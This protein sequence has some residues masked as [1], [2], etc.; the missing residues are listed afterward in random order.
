MAWKFRRGVNQNGVTSEEGV[1]AYGGTYSSVTSS[2]SIRYELGV[3]RFSCNE[4][5]FETCFEKQILEPTVPSCVHARIIKTK[6]NSNTNYV[7]IRVAR[8]GVSLAGADL[9]GGGGHRGPV[10]PPPPPPLL[11]L[12]HFIFLLTNL[13][14]LRCNSWPGLLS[15]Q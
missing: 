3:M 4:I 1:Q 14:P 15:S 10:P 9:G 6:R 13:L 8:A 5:G 11:L 7:T 12:H 2:G